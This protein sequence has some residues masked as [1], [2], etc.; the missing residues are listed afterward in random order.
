MESCKLNTTSNDHN[1]KSCE[2][3][4]SQPS[5]NSSSLSEIFKND[6]CII[7]FNKINELFVSFDRTKNIV[8]DMDIENM[9][10]NNTRVKAFFYYN[11][12]NQNC[13]C[14]YNVHFEC[15]TYWL[16]DNPHCPLCRNI[17]TINNRD[18][19]DSISISKHNNFIIVHDK[20]NQIYI[21]LQK[22]P[23]LDFPNT[24]SHTQPY[25]HY[26][27]PTQQTIQHI[28]NQREYE[29]LQVLQQR[30][31]SHALSN[32]FISI[33]GIVVVV[34]VSVIIITSLY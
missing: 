15:L 12:K 20:Q 8:V 23:Y 5:S 22:C 14:N 25:S 10:Q 11:L 2:N 24:A 26:Q 7:C 17:V 4:S 33:F 34:V 30:S 32:L 27:S 3:N 1:Y 19:V 6:S 29:E 28:Q 9:E 16:Y 21:D 18:N 13:N 31:R